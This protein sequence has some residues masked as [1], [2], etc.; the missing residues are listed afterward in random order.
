M[1]NITELEKG[2][3]YRFVNAVGDIYLYCFEY[4][5]KDDVFNTCEVELW[6][7]YMVFISKDFITYLENNSSYFDLDSY[8]E[9]ITIN[10]MVEYLPKSHPE[11]RKKKIELLLK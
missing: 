6:Y 1:K 11:L 7:Y 8:F 4:N 10:D 2:K 3:Y 9:V 5:K